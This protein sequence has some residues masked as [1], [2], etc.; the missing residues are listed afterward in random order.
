MAMARIIRKEGRVVP[1][2]ET[3]LPFPPLI[4][5]PTAV[6]ILTAKMPGRD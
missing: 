4:L 6:A 2:A 5:S 3:T 1:K